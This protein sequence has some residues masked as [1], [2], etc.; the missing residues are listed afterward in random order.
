MITL[1]PALLVATLRNPIHAI[2]ALLFVF[3]DLAILLFCLEAEFL[4]ILL[5]IVYLGAIAV[6]F[7]FVV[8]MMNISTSAVYHPLPF[9]QYQKIVMIAAIF[10]VLF[11]V[12]N[13]HLSQ[14]GFMRNLDLSRYPASQT[15]PDMY[16]NYG[17]SFNLFHNIQ[18]LGQVMYSYHFLAFF[19]T[20]LVLLVA[21]VGSIALT[22]YHSEEMKRQVIFE[23][24]EH[25]YSK[26][27]HLDNIRS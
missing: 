7:L 26:S 27:L 2:L 9:E 12:R 10:S 6:L 4:A 25:S 11:V 13:Y 8:M 24:L 15:G 16:S 14:I 3:F 23:Q 18:Y 5:L 20:G 21:M 1:I 19:L 17:A 22:I